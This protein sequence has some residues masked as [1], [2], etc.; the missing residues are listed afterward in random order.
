MGIGTR[1]KDKKLV[2]IVEQNDPAQGS[3][4][5][6]V[7]S[8]DRCSQANLLPPQLLPHRDGGYRAGI[9]VPVLL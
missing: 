7:A 4:E 2:I 8:A 5:L 3:Q 6:L 9:P 1:C